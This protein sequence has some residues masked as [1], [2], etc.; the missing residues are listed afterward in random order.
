MKKGSHHTEE[1][2]QKNRL[3]QPD[4]RGEKNK[5]WGKHH[6]EETRNKLRLFHLGKHPSEETRKKMSMNNTRH[7]LGKHPSDETRKRM[8]DNH[9]DVNGE[10]NPFFGKTPW[11][12]GLKNC[13]SDEAVKKMKEANLGDRHYSWKGE[14][15]KYKALHNWLKRNK[16]KEKC[17][18]FCG[19]VK[20]I[21]LSNISGEYKRDINDYQWLC[22]SC[23]RRY[24]YILRQTK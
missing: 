3:N 16:P 8:S 1:S 20:K 18:E 10:K 13:F 9:A 7:M 14:D 19:S 22:R 6:S 12:K 4:K 5:M 11:N 21:E 24:D 2:K 17:C 15:V 23:H